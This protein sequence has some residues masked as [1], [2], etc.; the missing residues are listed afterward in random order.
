MMV[1][2]SKTEISAKII[3]RKKLVFLLSE[4]D[5]KLISTCPGYGLCFKLNMKQIHE[6]VQA[7]ESDIGFW[8]PS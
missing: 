5:Q 2:M 7:M 3:K 4:S 1:R 8:W 6:A